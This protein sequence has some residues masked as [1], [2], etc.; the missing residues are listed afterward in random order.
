[1]INSPIVRN[2]NSD[3]ARKRGRQPAQTDNSSGKRILE[4]LD[5]RDF[6]W[7]AEKSG[8]PT[9]TLS[10]AV[11]R[12]IARADNAVRIA[13]A[14][15]TTVEFL[16]DGRDSGT[17]TP[18]IID[19]NDADWL[20]VAEFA[21][22]EIDEQGKMDPIS[23]TLFRRDW[24]YSSLGESAGLWI[25]RLPAPYDALTLGTGTPLFCKDHREG[26]RMIHGGYYLFRVNGGIV[27][28]RFALRDDGSDQHTVLARDLGHYEDQYQAVAR[29]VGQLA[30]PF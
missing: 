28:A 8:I 13:R 25:A 22:L 2:E 21:L 17:R 9:S 4:L 24:L 11:K 15:G 6:G 16:I 7:L 26:E 30:R 23:T 14:L 5:G 20:E 3:K 1:M 19:A 12:G 27:M 18:H 10:D 29:V